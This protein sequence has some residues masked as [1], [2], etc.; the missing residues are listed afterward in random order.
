MPEAE[1][2]VIGGGIA[3]ASTAFHLAQ[4][5]RN[6]TLLERGEIASEASGQNMGGLGGSGWGSMPGLQSYLTMGSVEIFKQL[7]NDMGYDMEFRLSGSLTAIHT[8]EQ[9]E[10]LQD[11]VQSLRS[12]GYDGE[13]L[14]PSEA[15]DHFRR[16]LDGSR[17]EK[18]KGFHVFRHSFASN[19]AAAGVDQ[20]IIDEWMGHQTEEM[21]KR[22]RHLFP[23]QQR[24]A[25]ESVFG[26]NGK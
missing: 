1:I 15:R 16:T 24:E 20:R 23:D 5:G 9:Y 14:T 2:L 19:L 22:Y 26:R 3:G 4:Q 6:V 21:R 11:R 18:I 17:W 12:N 25:I 7:Q 10:F 13:L 8:E